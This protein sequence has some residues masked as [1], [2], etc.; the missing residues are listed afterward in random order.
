MG[1]GVSVL[2]VSFVCVCIHSAVS[3]G[4]FAC[5]YV[6]VSLSFLGLYC[7]TVAI[8][9]RVQPAKKKGENFYNTSLT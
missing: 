5:V 7:V 4:V 1:V 8:W 2:C 9:V 3:E 6:S